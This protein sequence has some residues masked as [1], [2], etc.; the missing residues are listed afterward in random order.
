LARV[1]ENVVNQLMHILI[2][3][4]GADLVVAQAPLC[5]PADRFFLVIGK[6]EPGQLHFEDMWA[7]RRRG[8]GNRGR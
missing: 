2:A 1:L 6:V 7:P 3:V 5:R 8:C 4:F